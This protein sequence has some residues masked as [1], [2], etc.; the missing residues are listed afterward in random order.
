VLRQHVVLVTRLPKRLTLIYYPRDLPCIRDM[1]DL[2]ILL[3]SLSID[4]ESQLTVQ[5][6][7]YV[8]WS[9]FSYMSFSNHPA[10]PFPA[11]LRTRVCRKYLLWH[12]LPITFPLHTSMYWPCPISFPK[13]AENN[14][15]EILR[16]SYEVAI[17]ILS[18]FALCFG[19]NFIPFSIALFISYFPPPI[20]LY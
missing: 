6:C 1:H 4:S 13:K 15:K 20:V 17:D 16:H 3:L 12:S 18:E 14:G 8:C 11:V 7:M 10:D 19:V 5:V 2:P 9:P